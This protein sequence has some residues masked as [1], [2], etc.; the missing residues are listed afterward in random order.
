MHV[1][2]IQP[3]LQTRAK[4]PC[5]RKNSIAIKNAATQATFAGLNLRT[6]HDIFTRQ[7][8]RPNLYPLPSGRRTYG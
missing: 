8:R 2:L 4:A 1:N 7:V 5:L 6:S 3:V